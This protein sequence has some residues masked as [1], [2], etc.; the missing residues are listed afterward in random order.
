MSSIKTSLLSAAAI[1]AVSLS[2][3]G[4]S[5][6]DG[7][8]RPVAAAASSAA[9]SP[10][11]PPVEYFGEGFAEAEKALQNKPVEPAAPTF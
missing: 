10:A 9:S 6:A 4:C 11:F 3:V 5:R 8:G 1:V 7:E 2:I